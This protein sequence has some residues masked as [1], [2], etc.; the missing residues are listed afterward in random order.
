[1][2]TSL[3]LRSDSGL[4]RRL[5]L[6]PALLLAVEAGL[7][8][9]FLIVALSLPV[10][11]VSTERSEEQFDHHLMELA[12]VIA[13]RIGGDLHETLIT[14][15]QQSGEVH[16]R[17]QDVL[18]SIQNGVPAIYAL[19]TLRLRDGG[20]YMILDTARSPAL[21]RPTDPPSFLTEEL[22]FDLS[23]E[24]DMIPTLMAG[25]AYVDRGAYDAGGSRRLMRSVSTP[26]RDSS[27]AVV[28]LLSMDYEESLYSGEFRI[29]RD[30]LIRVAVAVDGMLVL[31]V[32]LLVYWLR[33]RI[34]KALDALALES[35]TDALTGLGNRRS[36][37]VR[38]AQSVAS[39]R[40]RVTPFSLLEGG[41]RP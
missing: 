17:L 11:R 30:Q 5:L 35:S 22:D 8:F 3:L 36:F 15:E 38:L 24:P 23:N 4:L 39:A 25:R 9:G 26:I 31:G 19:Y 16:A 10:L 12:T 14:R 41:E 1:M 13:T 21:Q 32:M 34:G 7:L 40:E 18:V 37:D 27:G 2:N 6:Q 33:R 28:A 20:L 29:R